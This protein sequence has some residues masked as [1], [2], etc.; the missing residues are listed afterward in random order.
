MKKLLGSFILLL[1]LL[2]NTSF[3]QD[4]YI[5]KVWRNGE[6]VYEKTISNIDSITLGNRY[7]S[8]SA[9][10][11]ADVQGELVGKFYLNDNHYICFSKG[12]LQQNNSTQEY[13]FAPYQYT[14]TI[15]GYYSYFLWNMFNV[16]ITDGGN[17]RGLWRV[18]TRAEWQYIISQRPNATSLCGAGYVNNVQGLILLPDDYI[19]PTD[20]SFN[21]FADSKDAYF[22]TPYMWLDTTAITTW[23]NTYTISDW[24][25]MEN[26]GAVFLPVYDRNRN[27]AYYWTST[28]FDKQKDLYSIISFT[29]AYNTRRVVL[30]YYSESTLDFYVRLITDHITGNETPITNITLNHTEETIEFGSTI[31]LEPINQTALGEYTYTSSNED[32]ATVDNYGYVVGTTL[33]DATITCTE[34]N[35]AKAE[36]KIHVVAPKYEDRIINDSVILDL[37]EELNTQSGTAH[38]EFGKRSFDIY[39][40]FYASDMAL[41]GSNYGWFFQDERMNVTNRASVIWTHYKEILTNTNSLLKHLNEHYTTDDN[42]YIYKAQ[43]LGL[44]GYINSQLAKWFIPAVGSEDLGGSLETYQALPIILEDNLYTKPAY[45]T[46]REVY[47]Q[48]TTDLETAIALYEQHAPAYIPE[49]KLLLSCDA[50]YGLLAMTYLNEC[51][52]MADQ[53]AVYNQ[54]VTNALNYAEKVINSNKYPLLKNAD[55]LTTGFNDVENAGWLWGVNTTTETSGGLKSF[56]GQVDI[57][58]YSYAWAGDTKVIDAELR[59]QMPNWDKRRL[60]FHSGKNEYMYRDCPYRKFFSAINNTSTNEEDVDH[61]WLSDDVYMRIESFYL[62]AAEAAWRLGDYT[63]AGYYLKQITDERVN[64]DAFLWETEYNNYIT[65]L[66]GNKDAIKKALIYNWRVEMWG[67]GYGWETF[68]RFG[69]ARKRGSNHSYVAGLTISPNDTRFTL[70]IPK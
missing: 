67:E 58:T 46:G 37:Y 35:G 10:S 7:T 29:I 51:V 59:D 33:G 38:D 43:L 17:K 14:T 4:D 26:A 28:L 2:C 30:G 24:E 9:L 48:A 62:I 16:P 13:R 65:N 12:N 20:I 49:D 47:N 69:E 61:K 40:D 70:T 8:A 32:I 68:K 50:L 53:P 15:S 23:P 66:T 44:R 63:K 55:L 31:Y 57:Y 56:F 21:S 19:Q 64:K 18:P 25:K 39:G 60:W 22:L 52:Y 5:Q 41:I 36:C 34:T 1:S 54:Y 11:D 42:Y 45:S 27:Y 6:V 3:A